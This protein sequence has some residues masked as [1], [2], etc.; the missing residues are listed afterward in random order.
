MLAGS[1]RALVGE[2]EV[3]F[4]KSLFGTIAPLDQIS[5]VIQID[6]AARRLRLNVAALPHLYAYDDLNDMPFYH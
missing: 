3:S 5:S 1:L 2:P 6:A 4:S